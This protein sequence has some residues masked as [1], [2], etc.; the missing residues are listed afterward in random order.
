MSFEEQTISMH[1]ARAVIRSAAKNGLDTQ[2]LMASAKILPN[3]IDSKT[4]RITAAQLDV[5]VRCYWQMADDE[6]LGMASEPCRYGIFA[7]MAEQAVFQK[8]LG[9]VY[10][11]ICRFYNLVCPGF[12]L[13]LAEQEE[14]ASLSMTLTSPAQD[15]DHMLTDLYLLIWHRFP[16]WLIGTWV[17]LISVSLAHPEPS[18]VEEYRL[19]FPCPAEFKQSVSR[20]IF[21]AR[22]LAKPVVQTPDS[23]QQHLA[24]TPL[25]WF[26][27]QSYWP[28]YSRIVLDQLQTPEQLQTTQIEPLAKQLNITSR[29]LRRK[30]AEEHTTFQALKQSAQRD[31]A[32]HLL[33]KGGLTLNQVAAAVGYSDAASFSRAFKSWTGVSPN[34]FK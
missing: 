27:R 1:Y 3:N 4:M 20:I 29:T 16:A 17:P 18:H 25:N 26:R 33:A 9:D 14:T 28:R 23:I 2:Q 24:E 30:L 19:L 13:T 34:R 7:L 8:T 5:L 22:L 31:L 12:S 21:P 10:R 15:A 11:Y 32:L 6:L